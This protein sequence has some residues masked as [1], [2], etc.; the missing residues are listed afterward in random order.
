[1]PAK[2]KEK[3]S[4]YIIMNFESNVEI[5]LF[6]VGFLKKTRFYHTKSIELLG[7]KLS[8]VVFYH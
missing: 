2:Y 3:D 5:V 8:P 6:F 1:M 7:W 4:N